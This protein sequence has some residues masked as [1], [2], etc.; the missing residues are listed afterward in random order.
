VW[1]EAT[2]HSNAGDA[3][4]AFAFGP[5]EAYDGDAGFLVSVRIRGQHWDGDHTRELMTVLADLWFR[6]G[7]VVRLRDRI[8][9][10]LRQPLEALDAKSLDGEFRLTRAPGQE[11][12]LTFGARADVISDRKPVLTVSFAAG[13]LQGSFL[14]VTDQSCLNIFVDELSA[15]IDGSTT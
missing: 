3:S 4:L 5:R 12:L 11:L 13:R 15:A 9:T 10:W 14:F 6:L 2:L 1:C 8:A 7:D